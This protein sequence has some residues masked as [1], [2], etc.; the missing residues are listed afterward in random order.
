MKQIRSILLLTVALAL[1]AG[2]KT[3]L[4][5]NDPII[6]R[7]E[8]SIQVAYATFDTFTALDNDNRELFKTKFP[9]VHEFAEWLRASVG[10]PPMPRGL[11]IIQS[12]NRVKLAYKSN[13]TAQNK[14]SLVTALATLES[15]VMES[16]RQLA[17]T[18]P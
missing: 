17:A 2:C 1:C 14:A 5:G 12:A 18:K 3:I 10:Q 7:A 16:Q 15:A 9:T 4:P 11:S 13:R 6:V 8:Q